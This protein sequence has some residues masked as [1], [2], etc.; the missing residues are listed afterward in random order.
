MQTKIEH[1][2]LAIS[3]LGALKKQNYAYNGIEI[4]SR[5][6]SSYN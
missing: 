4:H 1:E 3:N 2:I 6:S 5:P